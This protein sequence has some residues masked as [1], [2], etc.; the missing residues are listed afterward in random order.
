VD[1]ERAGETLIAIWTDES[2]FDTT[3]DQFCF[4]IAAIEAFITPVECVHAFVVENSLED[5]PFEFECPLAR[6][7]A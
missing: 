2:E 7:L 5:L 3:E 6:W 4:P 1:G